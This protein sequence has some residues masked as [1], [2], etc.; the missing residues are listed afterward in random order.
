M[1]EKWEDLS[2]KKIFHANIDFTIKNDKYLM[3]TLFNDLY[4]IITAAEFSAK[5]DPISG[6]LID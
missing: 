2:L 4:N 1:T 5:N 6:K 3:I